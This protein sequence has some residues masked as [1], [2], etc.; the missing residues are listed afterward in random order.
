MDALE[1]CNKLRSEASG[2]A[3][4]GIPLD[5]FPQK[6]QQMILD[7][8]RTENYSIEFTATSLISAMAAA[9][10]NSCYIRIK[11]N[12]ITS[13]I[14]YVILVGRPGVGKTPPLNFAYKPLHDI[15]TEEHH[16]FK[17]LK[18]E[19]AAIVER[20]K[21]K[22]RTEWESLPPVPVLHKNI[23]NDF[24]P[25]ILMRNHDA[26]LRGVA[27]VVDEIMGLFNTINRYNNSSF[28]QQM[29]SAHNGLPVDVSRCNLDCPLR[30]DYPCIQIVGTIRVT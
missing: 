24:T 14:L 9:V 27:V 4:S 11:G 3:T 23:M 20:N 29:L 22:K 2:V 28:V 30:I 12:W 16:K 13:P 17:A 26:N 25:E 5:V 8:A 1:I 21:G 10:G 15:D 7:L 6:M 19:Y 18:N